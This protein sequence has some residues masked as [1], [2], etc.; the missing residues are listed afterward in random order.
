MPLPLERSE[1]LAVLLDGAARD[2][3]RV[4]QITIDHAEL[5]VDEAYAIQEASINRRL[6]RGER[7]VGMK[8][9]LTSRAKM[10]QMGV[11]TPIYGHL[12]DAMLESDGALIAMAHFSQPRVEPE[13]AFVLGA[14]LHGPT[15]TAQALGAV[16]GVCIALEILD[17]RYADFAFT[18]PDV[19]AD[20]ASSAKFIL[21][22]RL[23][24]AN[25]VEVGCLGMVMTLAGGRIE[26]GSSA[27]ICEHPARSLT[28]LANMLAVRGKHLEAGQIVLTGGATAAVP[29]RRGDWVRLEVES[30]GTVSFRC[31]DSDPETRAGLR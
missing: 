16:S 10:R 25:N 28:A 23:V 2:G 8:M 7:V 15:S 21:G 26:V 31:A 27:A 12:T 5:S 14:D 30:L 19:V 20:N 1:G 29:I 3:R 22:N 9:G 24:D 17:S 6:A 18:L 4:P 13:I 11:Y